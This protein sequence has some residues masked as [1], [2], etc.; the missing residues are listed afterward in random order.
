MKK[1]GIFVDA[2]NYCINLWI[3]CVLLVFLFLFS[4]IL[5][6]FPFTFSPQTP[7]QLQV[8][9]IDFPN[10]L[11]G[12]DF[13]P[14]AVL[15]FLSPLPKCV[16]YLLARFTLDPRKQIG[17]LQRPATK[18]PQLIKIAFCQPGRHHRTCGPSQKSAF[19]T[20]RDIHTSV[21]CGSW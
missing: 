5:D 20:L 19:L 2:E 11:T 9:Q 15:W 6:V 1:R 18:K 17:A 16:E 8:W 3:S 13:Q 21:A 12:S 10:V 14:P 7:K 4:C